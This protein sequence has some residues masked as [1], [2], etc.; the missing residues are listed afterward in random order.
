M[1]DGQP[2]DGAEAQQWWGGHGSSSSHGR[3]GSQG[4]NGQLRALLLLHHNGAQFVS[5]HPRSVFHIWGEGEVGRIW[6][7]GAP[8]AESSDLLLPPWRCPGL[9][10]GA[11]APVWKQAGKLGHSCEV[12][13]VSWNQKRQELFPDTDRA[14]LP[15][16]PRPPDP[17]CD[18]REA[19]NSLE[20]LLPHLYDEEMGLRGWLGL[21]QAC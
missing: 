16:A 14:G 9:R 3:G 1:R 2:G 10:S 7:Q 12:R 6:V 8:R 19:A 21:E 15:S 11:R 20:S 5:Q 13:W 17:L 18:L 4:V